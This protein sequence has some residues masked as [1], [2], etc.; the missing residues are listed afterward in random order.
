MILKY[1]S[2]NG[3]VFDLKVGKFRTRTADYHTYAWLPK[4]I[5]QQYGEKVYRFDMSAKAYQTTMSVFGSLEEKKTFLNL[6]HAAF[7]H[8]IVTM[9]P[10]R[11]T[12]GQYYIDCYIT[13]VSTYYEEPWTQNTLTIY[14]PDSFWRR[15]INYQLHEADTEEYEYLDFD[16]DFMYDYR[17]TLPG[18][19]MITNP[20]VKSAD[21]ELKIKGYALNP[22]VVV[23]GMTIGV[24]AVIG[25]EETLIISSKTK[26]VIK[27]NA[28]GTETNLFNARNKTNSIFE[29][30]PSGE[31]PVMWS[32]AFDIDLTVF[33][34]RT[35]P[36][37]I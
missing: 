18:Y 11:I 7:D 1:S 14:C 35:E 31:L 22:M 5:A 3:Q 34:E 21:W 16:Y 36:L 6:L 26:T 13:E 37:W 25:T 33:E 9:T 29:P 19:A 28:N 12:H 8:D 27:V 15:D 23:G 24:N 20:G 32:G 30:F 10:G 17:A 2:S 4:T